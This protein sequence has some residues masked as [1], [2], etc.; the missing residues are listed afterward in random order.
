V[1]NAAEE[2]VKKR[3]LPFLTRAMNALGELRKLPRK[4]D[5]AVV[6][7]RLVLFKC[8]GCSSPRQKPMRSEKHWLPICK[9]GRPYS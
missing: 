3:P 4:K 6:N 5:E 2:G 8:L 7:D 9:V 1:W